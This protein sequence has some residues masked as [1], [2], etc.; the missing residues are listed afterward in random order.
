[1]NF[2]HLTLNR[3]SILQKN[4]LGWSDKIKCTKCGCEDASI[5]FTFVDRNT[6]QCQ[7]CGST[8]TII[9]KS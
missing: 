3:D 2:K 6:Y 5:N 4:N 9:L 1:M 8:E 7:N